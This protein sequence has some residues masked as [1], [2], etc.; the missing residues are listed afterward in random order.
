[1]LL[2]TGA[3]IFAL[4]MLALRDAIPLTAGYV[5]TVAHIHELLAFGGR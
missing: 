1:M 5:Q 3:M 4:K 2:T